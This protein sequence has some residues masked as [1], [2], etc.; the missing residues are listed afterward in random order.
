MTDQAKKDLGVHSPSR[1]FYEIGQW[2]DRGLGNGITSLSDMVVDAMSNG[3]L[4]P[5]ADAAS[6][7]RSIDKAMEARINSLSLAMQMADDILTS[8]ESAPVIRPIVDMTNANVAATQL[9]SLFGAGGYTS[10]LLS[11]NSA[12]SDRKRAM[13]LQTASTSIA[14][15]SR[16]DAIL[17]RIDRVGE[18]IYDLHTAI[19][20]MSVTIDGTALIGRIREPLTVSQG[21]SRSRSNRGI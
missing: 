15:D 12:S 21:L 20:G 2:V 14:D 13:L 10:G 19:D 1:V 9:N 5:I 8:S 4:L 16:I 18:R 6:S 3:V 17:S 7:D 11:Y